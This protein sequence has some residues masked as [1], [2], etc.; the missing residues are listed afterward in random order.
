MRVAGL[1]ALGCYAAVACADVLDDIE[2]VGS[3]VSSAAEEAT[4]SAAS[5][6]ESVTQSLEEKPTFTVCGRQWQCM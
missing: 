5:M 4:S 1:L 6:V 2:D 3:S